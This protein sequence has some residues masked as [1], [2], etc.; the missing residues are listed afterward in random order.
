MVRGLVFLSVALTAVLVGSRAGAELIVV[1]IDPTRNTLQAPVNTTIS[2]TFNQ[3]VMVPTVTNANFWAFGRWSGAV[4]GSFSFTNS[5]QTVVLTPTEP[6]SAGETVM[7]ILSHNLRAA[8][9]TFLRSQGYSYQFWTASQPSSLLFQNV[10]TLTCRTTPSQGTRAYGGIGSDLDNDGFLDLSIINEDTADVRVFM[11]LADGTGL[12]SSFLQPTTPIGFQ[13]SPNESADFN[14]DGNVDLC[15]SNGATS[16]VSVLLGNGNGTFSPQQSIPVGG[17]PRGIVVI[18]VDGDGDMDIVNAN[19]SSSNMSV[20]LNNG[21]GVFGSPT[22][23]ESGLNGEWPASAADLNEDGI[24]DIVIGSVS[25]DQIG[26]NLGNGNGTF[27][28]LPVIQNAGASWMIALGDLNGDGHIDVTSANSS[29]S[30]GGV[31]FGDGTGALTIPQFYSLDPFVIATDVGDVDGDGD[32]DWVSSSFS[33]DWRL[34]TNDGAGNFTV[35]QEFPSPQAASCALLLDIDNDGDL[36]LALIDELADVVVLYRQ[37]VGVP[38]PPN[39]Q[40]MNAIAVTSGVPVSG[41]TTTATNDGS[42]SCA[43]SATSAD[44]WYSYTPGSTGNV[45]ISTCNDADYD[46]AIAVF[47]SCFGNEVGCLDDTPGCALAT[48]E[49]NVTLTGGVTY[50]IRIAGWNGDTG[51]F[52]LTVTGTDL[53]IVRGNCNQDTGVDI[54]DA[55]ALLGLLFSGAGPT[56]CADACDINDDGSLDISDPIALLAFL[57]QGSFVPAPHPACGTDPTGDSLSCTA[58]A[59]CP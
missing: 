46:T 26:V 48:T 21:S 42:A 1:S 22:F 55:I 33:G 2:V 12:Y 37:G 53:S 6:F 3:P 34:L 35:N 20:M 9:G 32:L 4:S 30:N 25:A 24:M 23:Y 50:L 45:T 44:L 58:F 31:L 41:S 40:C 38:G 52:T 17:A 36:D 29:N 10:D 11:N 13:G 49:L 19:S 54:A 7:V 56:T 15:V 16:T 27:T 28:A 18:D 8:D 51:D 57:F 39:D 43:D 5:N 14:R 59:A 47:D